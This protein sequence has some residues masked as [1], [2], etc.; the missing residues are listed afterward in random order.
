[1]RKLMILCEDCGIKCCKRRGP[2][3]FCRRCSTKRYRARTRKWERTAYGRKYRRDSH[4]KWMCE[5]KTDALTYYGKGGKLLC[6]GLKCVV[7]D[8]DLLTLDHI[9]NNGAKHRA[10]NKVKGSAG[11]YAQLR[12]FGYPKG[13]QTLCWNHQWKKEILKRKRR[14]IQ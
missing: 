3:K 4:R 9:D 13:F 6:C 1:M 7:S 11:L 14:R 8:I 10:E 5:V 12:K 2:H